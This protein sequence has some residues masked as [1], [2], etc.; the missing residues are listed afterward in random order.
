MATAETL[1]FKRGPSGLERERRL[2]NEAIAMVAAG[3]APRVVVASLKHG[4][5]LLDP[6]RRLAL[7]SGVR[8]RPLWRD[9]GASADLAVELIDE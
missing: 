7:E 5:A 3:A 9:N 4:K 8:V 6:A 2:I 1:W